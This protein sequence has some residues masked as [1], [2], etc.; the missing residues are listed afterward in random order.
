MV[1]QQ[2]DRD[3]W[4]LEKQIKIEDQAEKSGKEQNQYP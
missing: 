3:D 4:R 1:R 2:V